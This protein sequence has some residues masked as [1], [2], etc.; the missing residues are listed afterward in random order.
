MVVWNCKPSSVTLLS[1][2]NIKS[3]YHETSS[4][5][6]QKIRSVFKKKCNSKM[7]PSSL[8]SWKKLNNLTKKLSELTKTSWNCK[9]FSS[10]EK[11]KIM[12]LRNEKDLSFV[13]WWVKY[14][15]TS[16]PPKWKRSCEVNKTSI[17]T[18]VYVALK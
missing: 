1:S 11:G 2:R 3:N 6:Q 9:I 16:L 8:V 13:E 12:L 18:S 7:I 4:Q 14:K 5:S 10:L 17:I 15:T